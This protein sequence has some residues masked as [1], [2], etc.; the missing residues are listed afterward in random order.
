MNIKR[1]VKRKCFYSSQLLY[2]FSIV[3]VFI[4]TFLLINCTNME[5][6]LSN[7]SP[8][9]A[10]QQTPLAL[11][12]HGGA[13]TILKK[14]MSDEVE[15][16]YTDQLTKALNMGFE[17]LEKGNNSVSVVEAVIKILE[18][19]PLFNAGK[20]SVFTH[21]GKNELDASIMDGHRLM[22][23]AVGGVRT[24]KNPIS[25]AREV[26]NS[27]PHV[28]MMGKGAERFAREQGL[29]IMDT[30]YFFT[31]KRWK[32]LQKFLEKTD[33]NTPQ[34]QLSESADQK[35]GT[36]GAV[37]LDKNGHLAAGTSTGGMT[38]KKYGRIG[39]SP[40]IGAGTYANQRCAVSATGHGEYFIRNVVAYDIAALMEYK[41]LS[42]EE[43]SNYVIHQKLKLQG[44]NGGVIALD[45]QANIAMPFNTAGMYRGF[46][47]QTGQAKVFIYK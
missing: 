29:D 19:S 33:K 23:G 37:A 34:T 1:F 43:A 25:A 17:L 45:N 11:V 39:D 18:D 12:I 42:L 14:N 32:H 8:D 9:K 46:I 31:E 6:T 35:M 26:M 47:K 28:M 22:A 20:G 15:K 16:K 5:K 38:N 21:D 41:K 44:G 40:I 24:I 7:S 3:V 13:G 27:S 36:V 2:Y 30:T 10:I 4:F